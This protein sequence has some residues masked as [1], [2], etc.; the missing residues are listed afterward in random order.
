MTK[1]M[2]LSE[3]AA[4]VGLHPEDLARLA[5]VPALSVRVAN[6]GHPI[7]QVQA[8]KLL[9]VLSKEHGRP[10]TASDIANFNVC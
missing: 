7:A 3:Y 6:G 10:V 5:N 8:N 4:S 9:A 1:K 2:T